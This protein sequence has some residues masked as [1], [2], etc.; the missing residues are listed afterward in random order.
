[1][2]TKR[3]KAEN[4][5]YTIKS[6]KLT[7]LIAKMIDLTRINTE[8]TFKFSNEVLFIFSSAGANNNIHAFKSYVF[9]I[10]DLFEKVNTEFDGEIIFILSDAKKVSQ[11]LRFYQKF[12]DNIELKLSYNDD[13]MCT[14]IVFKND[15]LKDDIAGDRK[16]SVKMNVDIDQISE[17][18][19]TD[20][21]DYSFT[22]NK[23]DFDILKSK[24]SLEKE[25]E[26]YYLNVKD[27][28][29]YLGENKSTIYIDDVDYEDSTISF[30][31][32]YFN[33]LN[34]EKSDSIKIWVFETFILA[35][36]ETTNL[37]ITIELTI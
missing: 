8:I 11:S 5:I 31:K 17:A 14:R 1:M 19:N 9:K 34:F 32:K 15:K 6:E 26:I 33:T 10:K 16:S 18:M 29:L 21:A 3:I 25:N 24:S 23:G 7:E 13:N 37:L 35:L 28:K 22:I 27:K 36:S 12:S 2:A 4:I 20:L 30:P